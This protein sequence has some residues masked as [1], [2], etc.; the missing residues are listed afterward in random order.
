MKVQ[1]WSIL[2]YHY[3]N[4]ITNQYEHQDVS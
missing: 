4:L 1:K 3:N 2:H